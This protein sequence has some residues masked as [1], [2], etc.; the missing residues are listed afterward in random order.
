[1][2]LSGFACSREMG[3]E[4]GGAYFVNGGDR[5]NGEEG[6]ISKFGDGNSGDEVHLG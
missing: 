1:M 6:P 4:D 2:S 5:W 3:L